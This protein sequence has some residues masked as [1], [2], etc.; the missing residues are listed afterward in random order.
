MRKIAN[1]KKRNFKVR[2]QFRYSKS[3]VAGYHPHYIFGEI[4]DKY[5]SLGMTTHPKKSMK[6][7]EIKSPNPNYHGK[8]YLQK[9]VFKMKKT[10]F[11]SKREKGWSFADEDKSLV[12]HYKKKFKKGK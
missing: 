9:K 10:S 12:R 5:I 1:N 3:K 11:K 8:Q 6:V 2:N 7:V 4:D